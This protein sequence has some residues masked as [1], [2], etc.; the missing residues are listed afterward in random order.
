MRSRIEADSFFP[1]NLKRRLYFFL[2]FEFTRNFHVRDRSFLKMYQL[3]KYSTDFDK[4]FFK[5]KLEFFP[6][7]VTKSFGQNS[8]GDFFNGDS[9]FGP[10]I[11]N[12][13]K[14]FPTWN[15]DKNSS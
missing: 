2:N 1:T 14:I 10:K 11:H 3:K 7:K 13:M 9:K 8:V 12:P 4:L 5:K 15:I 6:Y